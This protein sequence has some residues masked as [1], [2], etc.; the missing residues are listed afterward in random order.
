MAAGNRLTRRAAERKKTFEEERGKRRTLILLSSSLDRGRGKRRLVPAV[1]RRAFP[2]ARGG[3]RKKKIWPERH[4]GRRMNISRL[5]GEREFPQK[6]VRSRPAPREETSKKGEPKKKK[7]D[8]KDESGKKKPRDAE[9]PPRKPMKRDTGKGNRGMVPE[10]AMSLITGGPKKLPQGNP[11]HL[12][13][14]GE[15]RK[16]KWEGVVSPT[17]RPALFLGGSRC[18]RALGK[19]KRLL[20]GTFLSADRRKRKWA[21]SGTIDGNEKGKK[22][23]VK[24]KKASGSHGY[25][26]FG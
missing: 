13:F 25:L 4:K 18:R 5:K 1:K 3:G 17:E 14:H 24:K 21:H 12:P 8:C 10:G 6:V 9:Q 16:K 15:Y 26:P 22:D 20:R 7:G 19:K 23:C 2:A 11:L